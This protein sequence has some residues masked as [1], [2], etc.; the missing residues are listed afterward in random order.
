VSGSPALARDFRVY[1][2]AIIADE[3]AKQTVFVPDLGLDI[4]RVCV[5]ESIA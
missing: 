2:L 5:Q 3:Q 1:P 4:A